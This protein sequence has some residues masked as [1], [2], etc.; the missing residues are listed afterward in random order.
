MAQQPSYS[1]GLLRIASA[2]ETAEAMR[3]SDKEKAEAKYSNQDTEVISLVS[4]LMN[5]WNE[6]RQHKEEESGV[7]EQMINNLQARNNEYSSTKRD[8]IQRAGM[9]VVYMGLTNVKCSHA[10]AWLMDIFSSSERTWGIQPTPVPDPTQEVQRTTSQIVMAQL[11][12]HFAQGGD[13]LDPQQFQEILQTLEPLAEE[14]MD[15]E[16]KDRALNMENKIYDQM[17]EGHWEEAFED[18]LS[19]VVTLKA[20]IIKGPIARKT[21]KIKYE[22]DD[23]GN[24]TRRVVEEPLPDYWRISP[25]DLYPSPTSEGVND[26]DLV[27]KVRFSRQ[28]LIDL[29]DEPGYN[30]EAINEILENFSTVNSSDLYYS[31]DEE[32]REEVED[33]EN[34]MIQF[35][36]HIEGLEF[37]CSVQGK[38][39]IEY[40]IEKIP[41]VMK[42]GEELDPLGE[43]QINALVVGS[44]LI[45]I[46]LNDDPLGE[47]PYSKTGWRKIPGS[48]WYK[49]VPELMEDLQRIINAAVRA[50]CYNMSMASGPQVEVDTDRLVPGEDLESSYPGKVWQ[51]INRANVSTPAVRFFNPDSNSAELFGIY[52]NFARLADDY[53][54]IPAYAY[55][56]D[57]VA[58]AGR[59]SSGLSMLMTSAAKGIKRV[60]LGIDKDIYKTIVRR[61]FD[62]N[63]RYDPDTEIKG[64]VEIV[65][66]GA[67]A[68]MVKEQMSQRRMEFL[69]AT[70]NDV[71]IDLTGFDGRANVLREAAA[72]LE[73]ENSKVVKDSE[74]VRQMVKQKE[75]QA[76][77]A[78]QAEMEAAQ[79]EQQLRVQGLQLDNQ[80]KQMEVLVT[81]NKIEVEKQKLALEA[82]KLELEKQ[83]IMIEAGKA[84]ADGQAKTMKA[85]ADML[86]KSTKASKLGIDAL[87]QAAQADAQLMDVAEN[88]V[89]M[90]EEERN[91]EDFMDIEPLPDE[92]GTGVEA[93][94][95]PS[96]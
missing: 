74:E 87:S 24:V 80:L 23:N 27:E 91:P 77:A 53:T 4:Y 19:D 55:G 43:Y 67:V 7:Q 61:Q 30:K 34:Q 71:D 82:A 84:Q 25:L 68:V 47:R 66:T 22:T 28:E 72:S 95:V 90:E 40:G 20:G 57:R 65:T 42:K 41:G 78:M 63:M 14:V 76:E 21:K 15:M 75:A 70:N 31:V 86:D 33:K 46:D 51:T 26:G 3:Q 35:R 13:T 69:N 2:D 5:I 38:S 50:M 37:W 36:T 9:P 83:K 81:Q 10:E 89:A 45:Y 92:A 96:A 17:V 49:G 88:E 94:E 93:E 11:Q 6:N 58:G 32:R 64:D 79:A 12:E 52:E 54:G 56:S 59:T 1:G 8:E 29:K 62:W 39:L 85:Q 60:I 44:T 48:F 16:L 18:F 73:M